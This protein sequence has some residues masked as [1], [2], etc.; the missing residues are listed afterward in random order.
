MT[1]T[2]LFEKDSRFYEFMNMEPG[3]RK[4]IFY[5]KHIMSTPF[6]EVSVC[7]KD[8]GH[9]YFSTSV[10]KIKRNKSSYYAQV[11]GKAGFTINP[12]GKISVW[13]GQNIFQMSQIS[14]FYRHMNYNWLSTNLYPYITKSILEK[15]VAGK[16]TNNIDVCR[17]YLKVMRINASPKLFFDVINSNGTSKTALLRYMAVAKDV[18][19][20]LEWLFNLKH[21]SDYSMMDLVE[22]AF[23]LDRKIDYKW[24][25]NRVRQEHQDW[26]KEIMDVEM[27]SLPD[28]E[29]P[30][31]DKVSTFTQ[32]GFKLLETTKEVYA[33]GRIMQH[34][35]Y[36]NYSNSINN[37]NYLA[38]HVT[39]DG[40]EATLGLDIE[41]FGSKIK[42]KLNQCTSIRNKPISIDMKYCIEQFIKEFNNTFYKQE[43]ELPF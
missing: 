30:L 23:I 40:E 29:I 3:I 12:K 37:G 7:K 9:I 28:K 18:N 26:T 14:F 8:D 27:D 35:L 1:N 32:S 13:F 31:L 33:E 20:C 36:T 6:P 17:A 16:I 41:R 4:N 10:T 43:E 24:S 34:C 42:A 39:I 21:T 38:Y 11:S 22:Q 2:I 19:H 15:M 25:A 5:G